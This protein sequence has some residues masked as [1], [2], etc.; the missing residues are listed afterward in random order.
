MS[1][2]LTDSASNAPA[3]AR[4]TGKY[5]ALLS[6]AGLLVLIAIALLMRLY[7]L[8]APYD[9]DSYDEGVYWQTL[10]AMA[11]GHRLYQPT[12]Y[13]QPPFF[14]LSVYPFYILL[15]QSIWSARMGVALLSLLGIPAA[16]LLG[17]ALRGYPG[18]ILATLLLL[19]NVLY[20][21]A[22]Q[23][24]QAEG[25]QVSL[26][27]VSIAFAFLW[28]SHPTGRHGILYATLCTLTLALSILTKLFSVATIV[29]IALLALAYLWRISRQKRQQLFSSSI[30]LLV[31]VVVLVIVLLLVLIPFASVHHALLS[32]V[33]T[34]HSIAKHVVKPTDNRH[35]I[36]QA[37]NTPLSYAALI[38]LAIALLKRDWLVLPLLAWLLAS[39]Y[40][41][42]QEIPLFPHHFVIIVPP[43]IALTILGCQR[44]DFSTN[45]RR[46]TASSTITTAI[47]LLAIIV[48]LTTGLLGVRTYYKMVQANAVSLSTVQQQQVATDLRTATTSDQEVITDSQFIAGLAQRSTPPDLV[49]TS[50]VRINSGYISTQQ[51]IDDA[52]QP[53]VH[54]VLFYTGR[55]SGLPGLHDW[56]KKHFHLVHNYGNNQELWLKTSA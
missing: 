24:L 42:W 28:L 47:S 6:I 29:P 11:A 5:I 3:S 19:L 22:S 26:A 35:L 12:F 33:I 2:L 38:G 15:G 48:V 31:G 37:L 54:A 9:R 16:F 8:H 52:S 32:Q 25:P 56:V 44:I 45:L 14:L 7:T 41:L 36:L 55:F 53:Q 4:R 1:T 20:L 49:D 50:S 51:V 46:L 39:L 40:L 27:L 43:L 34:F 13:S 21:S 18:A 30:S 23:T 10:R 17:K